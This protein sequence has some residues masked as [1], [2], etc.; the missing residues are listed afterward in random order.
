MADIFDNP[1]YGF[2]RSKI[3][4][5]TVVAPTPQ[6]K[7]VSKLVQE[8]DVLKSRLENLE[9]LI[10]EMTIKRKSKI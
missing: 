5:W 10:S 2:V 7:T 1:P 4:G 6:R 9:T 8:N 3:K